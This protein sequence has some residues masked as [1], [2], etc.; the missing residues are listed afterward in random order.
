MF[1]ISEHASLRM[2][3]RGITEEDVQ[4]CFDHHNIAF[5]PKEGYT[6][7]IANHPNG[8]RLQ[9]VVNPENNDLVTALWLD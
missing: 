9:I 7:Y 3:Q 2:K 8:R 4:Y 5:T 1:N 6:L